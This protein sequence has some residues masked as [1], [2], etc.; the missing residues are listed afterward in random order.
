VV[1][2]WFTTRL[3]TRLPRIQFVCVRW[4]YVPTRRLNEGL[5]MGTLLCSVHS[6]R[7]VLRRQD[8]KWQ[9]RRL[10]SHCDPYSQS[11]YP[12]CAYSTFRFKTSVL[13]LLQLTPWRRSTQPISSTGLLVLI[14]QRRNGRRQISSLGSCLHFYLKQKS[15]VSSRWQ[16]LNSHPKH[17]LTPASPLEKSSRPFMPK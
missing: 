17:K 4:L 12:S 11:L 1:L 3:G 15:T 8:L 10:I 7:S 5:W 13:R 14:W 16:Y 6:V 9:K 2:R